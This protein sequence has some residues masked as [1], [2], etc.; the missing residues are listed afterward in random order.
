MEKQFAL[1]NE[2]PKSTTGYDWLRFLLHQ[3]H[4][5]ASSDYVLRLRP[6]SGFEALV[7]FNGSTN[8]LRQCVNALPPRRVDALVGIALIHHRTKSGSRTRA[9]QRS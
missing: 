4:V 7:Y 2:L 5:S 9:L 8:A 3:A 1:E 6:D